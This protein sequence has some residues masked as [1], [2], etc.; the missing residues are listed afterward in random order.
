MELLRSP[1]SKWRSLRSFI[2]QWLVHTEFLGEGTEDGGTDVDGVC[3][4]CSALSG[5]KK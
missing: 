3:A 4:G 5:K 1:S 2:H